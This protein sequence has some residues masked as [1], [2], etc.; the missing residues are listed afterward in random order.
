MADNSTFGK[1]SLS[2]SSLQKSIPEHET[3]S[4]EQKIQQFFNVPDI[5]LCN[6]PLETKELIITTYNNYLQFTEHI[7][8]Q[9][10]QYWQLIIAPTVDLFKAI[11]NYCRLV[12]D[13][14]TELTALQKKI[15]AKTKTLAEKSQVCDTLTTSLKQLQA[16]PPTF[17]PTQFIPLSQH[18]SL[19]QEFDE[20][21]Q[22]LTTICQEF[23]Q[24]KQ[25]HPEVSVSIHTTSQGK[26]ASLSPA[27]ENELSLYKKLTHDFKQILKPYFL[28]GDPAILD[29]IN[30]ADPLLDTL[31]DLFNLPDPSP[32]DMTEP[33]LLFFIPLYTG[34]HKVLTIKQ[35]LANIEAHAPLANWKDPTK[36]QVA[37]ARTSGAPHKIFLNDPEFQAIKDWAA[38]KKLAI[39]RFHPYQTAADK[40]LE[41]VQC[42]QRSDEPVNTYINR[43]LL[44]ADKVYPKS[45]D[46]TEQPVLEK[47]QEQGKIEHFINGLTPPLKSCLIIKKPATLAEAITAARDYGQKLSTTHGKT[48]ALTAAYATAEPTHSSLASVH[49]ALNVL[50]TKL[51]ALLSLMQ[52]C[53]T[54]ADD[55]SE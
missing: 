6:I 10:A 1:D 48:P 38:F 22:K 45:S 32:S 35:H 51:D 47:Y 8:E 2:Q 21:Q 41:L 34:N 3:R 12:A 50:E 7:P 53:T 28:H 52:E 54:L 18:F 17:D 4:Y 23:D 49:A 31:S 13:Y 5:T 24:Y 33:N 55:D 15:T 39:D 27:Q 37:K 30:Y 29:N 25:L 14:N 11:I 42:G 16:Q 46:P 40:A 19:Q 44:I 43:F 26:V 36:I 9:K 20:R